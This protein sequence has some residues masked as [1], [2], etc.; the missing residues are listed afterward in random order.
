VAG[1]FGVR[2][3]GYTLSNSGV[4][5]LSN[6]RAMAETPPPTRVVNMNLVGRTLVERKDPP[7]TVLFVYNNNALMTLPNQEAVRKGL[8][9]EDLFTIVFDQAM[10]DTAR[11]ADLILPA[12]TFLEHHELMRGY[13]AY[14]IQE[15]RPVIERVG[16]SRPNH[17]VFGELCRRLHLDRP[18]D[19]TSHEEILDAI[20]ADHPMGDEGRRALQT[21]GRV[22]PAVGAAPVQF[23]DERPRTPDGKVHL[24][25]E[26]L[27]KE[28]PGGLYAYRPDPASD[29]HPLAL[30]SPS[31][32]RTISSTFGQLHRKQVPVEIHPD[33]A[34]TRGIVDGDAV[35]IFNDLGEVRCR[36]RLSDGIR[37]GVVALPKGL[38]S[39]NT[40]NGATSNAVSPD[41]LTDLGGGACFNDARVQIERLPA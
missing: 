40:L 7:V 8:L 36:A 34:G 5:G 30:I 12:T 31:T 29:V 23:V 32:E 39:H 1:K 2:G 14:G 11:Y 9:R 15:I 24:C 28:A 10:T 6:V 21:G 35:R 41:S 37:P 38:W 26:A 22:F 33:D 27:D 17:E 13:G 3:G 19:P 18:G 4:Y 16:E 25:P 20:L